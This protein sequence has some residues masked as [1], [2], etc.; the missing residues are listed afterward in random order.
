M[1]AAAPSTQLLQDEKGADER[2][3]VGFRAWTF[4]PLGPQVFKPNRH[5]WAKTSETKG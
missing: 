2:K 4:S 1:S 5:W 3:R